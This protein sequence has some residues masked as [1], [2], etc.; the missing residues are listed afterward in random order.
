MKGQRAEEKKPLKKNSLSN[1]RLGGQKPSLGIIL[2][3]VANMTFEGLG[4]MF[5]GYSPHAC[6]IIFASVD[7]GPR[8]GSHVRGPGS[9][10]PHQR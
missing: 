2:Q 6:Q 9:K 4:D 8:G 10:D 7:G 3:G 1:A 5:E